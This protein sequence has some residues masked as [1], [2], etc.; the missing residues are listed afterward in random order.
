[1]GHTRK[2][3]LLGCLENV[4]AKWHATRYPVEIAGIRIDFISTSVPLLTQ[5]VNL[6][7]AYEGKGQPV[8]EIYLEAMDHALLWEDAN[9]EFDIQGPYVV[10]RDFAAKRVL[11]SVERAVAILPTGLDDSI[12]NLLR[13]FM[14]PLLLKRGA[15]LMHAAGLVRDG[16]GYVFFGQS[17]AGK[18]TSVG[19]AVEAD[20]EVGVL[21]D[22][23]VIIQMKHADAVPKV[24]TAPFGSGILKISPLPIEVPLKGLYSLQQSERNQV[25]TIGFA[26]GV[27]SLLASA[28]S[29]RFQDAVD[30]RIS[31]ATR[32]AFSRIGIRRLYFRKDPDFWNQ[33]VSTQEPWKEVTAYV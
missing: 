4:K 20:R 32:F 11:D 10:Q 6:Y 23:A 19:L 17:G 1:M 16:M 31:L 5:I 29:V 2:T 18:S 26:E 7:S 28:M 14:P 22:D 15:F 27:A 30:D 3:E 33:V 13:W 12:H 21:G 24:L 25:G 9:S 8:A